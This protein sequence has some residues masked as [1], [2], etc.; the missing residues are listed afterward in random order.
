MYGN[1]I[2]VQE[3]WRSYGIAD[4]FVQ[5]IKEALTNEH[6]FDNCR[7]VVF[8]VETFDKLEINRIISYLENPVDKKQFFS[9]EDRDHVRRFRRVVWYE[10]MG[11]KF[12]LDKRTGKPI[13]CTGPCLDPQLPIA[14][15]AAEEQEYWLMWKGS[16]SSV[17]V[18]GF[19][20]AWEDCVKCVYIEI[21]AKS[22]VE[23]CPEKGVEYWNYAYSLISDLLDRH[24]N[25]DISVGPYLRK[26][27][28]L[29]RRSEA[30][31]IAIAV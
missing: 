26:E 8:E 18:S 5:A 2:A 28:D 27:H 11:Y 4:S 1:Y 12:F 6:L 30:L 17:D 20:Q 22:L 31:K 9:P 14:E 25:T 7:G 15:W 21:L 10:G 29:V 24:K 13:I 19:T 23:R 16:G 3:H